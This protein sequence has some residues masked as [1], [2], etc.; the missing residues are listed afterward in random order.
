MTNRKEFT[1]STQAKAFLKFEGKCAYCKEKLLN[2]EDNITEYDHK[3]ECWQYKEFDWDTSDMNSLE[4]CLPCHKNCHKF[5]SK[6]STSQRAKGRRQ[7]KKYSGERQA[8]GGVKAST[9][10]A[11]IQSRPFA[12][13]PKGYKHKWN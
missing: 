9:S 5:K 8:G 13:K 10:R 3:F 2:L 1:K 6:N 12:Q 4:N 7:N 11:K